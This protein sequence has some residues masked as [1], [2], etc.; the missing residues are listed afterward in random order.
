[1]VR[2]FRWWRKPVAVETQLKELEACGVTLC[3]GVTV[4]HV[5]S[6]WRYYTPPK[7]IEARQEETDETQFRRQEDRKKI[8][9]EPYALIIQLLGWEI[10]LEPH[11]QDPISNRFWDVDAE[12]VDDT[13]LYAQAIERLEFMTEK[14]LG[15]S[16]IEGDIDFDEERFAYVAFT[17]KGER[18][19]W[20]F[21]IDHDWMD[22]SVFAKYDDLLGAHGS[23]MRLHFGPWNQGGIFAAFTASEF[24]RFRELTKL[25]FVSTEEALQGPLR[26][27]FYRDR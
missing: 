11:S 10:D 6:P 24:A 18:I 19:R 3:P 1:M 4:E 8:E 9:A 22:F 16:D 14:V 20:D 12:C 26:V 5:I 21:R 15:L 13:R 7:F 23:P 17:Y 2:W 27:N 25:E